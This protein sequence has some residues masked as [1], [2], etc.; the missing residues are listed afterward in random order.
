MRTYRTVQGDTWDIIAYKMYGNEL[1]MS[2]LIEANPQHRE[3]VIFPANV[4]M[5]VPDVTAA[6]T[7]VLPPWRR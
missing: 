6:V 4:I 1:Q 2:L 5:N 3:I 7:T